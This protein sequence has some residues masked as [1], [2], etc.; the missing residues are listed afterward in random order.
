EKWWLRF[1]STSVGVSAFLGI[2]GLLQLAGKIVINQGGVR[3]DGTFGNAAYF[4]GYMLVHIFL[5][6]FL[7][8][9]HKVPPFAKWLYGGALVLQTVTLYYTATRGA[10]VGLVAGLFLSVL[11]VALGERKH[12]ELRGTA[13][14]VL[15]FLALFVGTLYMQKESAFVKTNTVLSR[16][17]SISLDAAK[18]RFMVWG[19]ALEGFKERPILG[20]GQEG[21]N[22]VFNKYYNP[23]MWTQEQWFDRTHNIFFD[24]LI[25][26]GIF[27][28]LSYLMLF[29]FLLWY[30]WVGSADDHVGHFSFTEKSILTGLLAGYMVH[31]FFVFDNLI[32]YLLFFS[33]IAFIHA[34]Y[35]KPFSSLEK[36]PMLQDEQVLSTVG[37]SLIVVLLA[38]VYFL[39]IR[40]ITVSRNLID[41]LRQQPNGVT[42]NLSFYRKVFGVETV[43]T[44]EVAEQA[45]QAAA[46]VA[47]SPS[48]PTT[49]KEEFLTFAIQAM[50]REIARAPNDT[51]LRMFMGGLFNGLGR[52]PEATLH[53]EK[54]YELSPT[55][56][57]VAFEL[58][59]TYLN[60][61]RQADAFTLV[62]RAFE[63]APEFEKARTA[64]ITA[65]IYSKEFALADELIASS[66]EPGTRIDERL[67]KAYFENKQF[68]K[69]ISL[70]KL[71]LEKNPKDPQT[72]VSL[73][74]AYLSNG[75]R[76]ESIRELETVIGLDSN[77][78]KQ[79]EYYINEIKAGR[80]P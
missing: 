2:Y 51:R 43:G 31:N 25:S 38:G 50:S 77:F 44:Q 48:V 22:Y 11:L 56:Q 55:K 58:A 74:A 24:W 39:N 32:S 72:H 26:A 71:R 28:L 15:I 52:Y 20:W 6:L 9:R 67:V 76:A 59:N 66:T 69:A 70:L 62:K 47:R 4:A 19:M 64:Y 61:N 14:G 53:L 23:D 54:A 49:V 16:F 37:A 65:A 80:N 35:G 30:L 33:L 17:A 21:F 12:K 13:I 57:T 1:F 79:G 10:G 42:E 8:C 75:N 7:L 3:L 5:S 34:R 68:A 18:P 78:K 29:V 46:N 40:P 45:M 36:A 27:G 60:T 73:A 41:A 63:S